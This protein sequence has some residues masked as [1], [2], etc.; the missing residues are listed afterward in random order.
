VPIEVEVNAVE[1]A[2]PDMI[3]GVDE[4]HLQSFGSAPEHRSE[5]LGFGAPAR[6]YIRE[7]AYFED[8]RGATSRM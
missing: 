7:A 5:R 3:C 2:G 4:S 6:E 1:F 8:G